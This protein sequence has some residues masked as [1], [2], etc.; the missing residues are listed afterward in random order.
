MPLFAY[1]AYNE[2][3]EV[4]SAELESADIEAV[5][6]QL[7]EQGLSPL[8]IHPVS[9]GWSHRLMEKIFRP[10]VSPEVLLVFTRQFHTLFKAG[11][12]IEAILGTLARQ[13]SSPALKKTLT[14][15]RA[16]VGSGGSLA[17]SFASHHSIFGDLYVSMLS[18]GEEA[19]IL[20]E[21]LTNLS[22]LLEK[23]ME[24]RS[25][26]KSATLY[27]KIVVCVLVGATTVLM[28]V[29]VP[30]FISFYAHYKA[31]LPLPTQILIGMSN[32][33]AHYGYIV[34][35]LAIGLWIG[36]KKYA[37]T[38]KGKLKVGAL[39]FKVP[40]FGPLGI[41]I[42]N[43]RFCHI[44]AALYKSGL[45]ITRCLEITGATIENGAFMHEVTNL[46]NHVSNGRSIAE[47]MAS[48]HY[49]TPIL[50]DA[51]AVGEK[52]G[53]LDEMLLSLGTHY[54]LE[55]HNQLKNLATLLEPFL[56]FMIFGMVTLFALAIFLP[57]WNLSSVVTHG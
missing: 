21:V 2:R 24:I 8:A 25:A 20:E 43:A 23:E 46:T 37:G 52:S 47:G 6:T 27:P 34:A 48:C 22:K 38:R 11:M 56:L 15:I 31:P 30:K 39:T 49:F 4:V 26:V 45:T 44:L 51:T 17:Q 35:V 19:G 55:V 36:F 33:M 1:R 54:D 18:A 12:N 16:D 57:I 50:I 10:H 40:V 3:G 41:K 13:S 42:A 7:G 28:T 5:Q 9:T 32:L 14:K 29:V 53:S